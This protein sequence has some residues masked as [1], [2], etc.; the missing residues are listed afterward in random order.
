MASLLPYL[1]FARCANRVHRRYPHSL[2]KQDAQLSRV[3]RTLTEGNF[4]LDMAVRELPNPSS[5]PT[6]LKKRLVMVLELP[7][8]RLPR[9]SPSNKRRAVGVVHSNDSTSSALS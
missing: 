4:V 8:P 7:L 5:S 2:L 1:E 9:V 6:P 3:E